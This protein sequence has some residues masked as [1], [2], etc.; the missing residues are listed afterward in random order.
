MR[1]IVTSLRIAGSAV[2]LFFLPLA[3]HIVEPM[4][5]F[6]IVCIIA[7]I[8]AIQEGYYIIKANHKREFAGE[9]K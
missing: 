6:T 4:Y 2:L 3:L 5:G 1:T 8:A 7:T 9:L